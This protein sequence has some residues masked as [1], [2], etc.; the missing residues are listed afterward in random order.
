[1]VDMALRVCAAQV[2][3]LVNVGSSSLRSRTA[4]Y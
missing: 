2:G 1:M 4:N 3:V